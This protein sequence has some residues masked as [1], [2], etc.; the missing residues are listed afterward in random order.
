MTY[1][2]TS[3]LSVNGINKII[4][5]LDEYQNVILPRKIEEL[6]NRLAEIGIS[7]AQSVIQTDEKVRPLIVFSKTFNRTEDGYEGLLLATETGQITST[8][9][10]KEG[11]KSADVSPLLMAE[12]GA[13]KFADGFIL[14]FPDGTEVGRGTFPGQTHAKDPNG[15]WYLENGEWKHSYGWKPSRPLYSAWAEMEKD[16]LTIAYE[17]FG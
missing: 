16:I 17:V 10:T 5:Q 15:W 2:F 12:Y 11:I 7:V 14:R 6:V 4:R 3:D 1:K 8:W 13:G 9:E